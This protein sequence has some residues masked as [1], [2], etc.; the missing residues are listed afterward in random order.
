MKLTV[1]KADGP[2]WKM[3]AETVE[4]GKYK[5]VTER[6]AKE[7]QYE[8]ILKFLHRLPRLLEQVNGVEAEETRIERKVSAKR[9]AR[10]AGKEMARAKRGYSP[11]KSVQIKGQELEAAQR[12]IRETK[13]I[14]VWVKPGKQRTMFRDETYKGMMVLEIAAALSDKEANQEV[15]AA[16]MKRFRVFERDIELLEGYASQ[17]KRY[18]ITLRR[19]FIS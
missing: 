8:V 13:E 9:A 3:I 12:I 7:P 17:C 1:L 10:I 4:D 2:G 19:A 18:K 16:L 11:S 14:T 15:I 6:V 5:V